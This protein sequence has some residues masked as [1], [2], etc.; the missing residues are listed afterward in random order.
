MNKRVE[1]RISWLLET[2]GGRKDIP[3]GDKY[4]PIIKITNPQF[5][6]DDYW[7]VFV[8]NKILLNKNETLSD[9]EYLSCLAPDNLS[10]GAEFM[11][12]EGKKLVA[13][14]IVLREIVCY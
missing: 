9:M 12:Y 11:L 7:S 5:E 10:I 4:A 13:K 2:Q 6:S 14:G 3:Y 1:A 8:M